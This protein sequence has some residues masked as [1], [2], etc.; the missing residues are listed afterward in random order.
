MNTKAGQNVPL[1]WG[2][3]SKPAQSPPQGD[4]RVL[5]IHPA[6]QGLD[7]PLDDQLARPYGLIPVGLAGLVNVLRSNGIFVQGI[8]YSLEKQL[9][10][11]FNLRNW[12]S[13][14]SKTRVI[15][16]DLHWY[17]HCFGALETARICKEIL[18]W[19][20]TVLG[21]L[22]ATGFSREILENFKEVDFIIRGDAEKPLLQLVQ[23]LFD[24][25]SS[26]ELLASLAEVPNLSYRHSEA[27]LE[28]DLTYT[29]TTADLD[30]LDF[31]NIDFLEHYREYY[32]H[33]YVVTNLEAARVALQVKPYLGKWT[34]TA[35]GC[36]YECSY[37][38]GCKSAHK[39][40][41]GRPELVVRS[42]ERVVDDLVQLKR[43]GVNQALL[44]YDIAEL[45]DDYVQAFFSNLKSS[46]L[47]IGLYNELFQLPK[48]EFLHQFFSLTDRNHSCVAISPLSGSERVRRLNGKHFSNSDLFDT[49]DI[50]NRNNAYVIVYFSLNLPG[51]DNQTIQESIELAREIV[52]F[53]PSSLLKILNTAHTLDPFSP[54][55]EFPE[56]YGI[57]IS[58]STF[59]DWYNY[60]QATKQSDR[61]AR[62]ELHRGFHFK[63][64]GARSVEKMADAW[65]QERMG[66]EKSVWPIPPGW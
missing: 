30:N 13:A 6:K 44:S 23:N 22:T 5:Y 56:K 33:E 46:G 63:D 8:N 52:D 55:A 43:S 3:K 18:P 17:E 12:L 59:M 29:A 41:A 11:E 35:R 1:G 49:L 36:K 50:L 10:P 54:M 37:C 58:M 53:Y 4:N 32:I 16:I 51:E 7:L 57:E 14:Q 60:C 45:G 25:T 65:D 40:L 42:P 15:L 62:T 66:K 64:A 20:W 21:G 9:N 28:N 47:K 26:T 24:K 38:G 19:A 27:I 31:I 2:M 61:K 34:C 48:P 39:S